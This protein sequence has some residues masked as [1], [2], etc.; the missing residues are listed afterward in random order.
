[1]LTSLEETIR[2]VS[3]SASPSVV[4]V[5]QN[6]RGS[7]FVVAKN[8]VLT[9][10][11]NLRDRS[12]AITFADSRMAQGILHGA[13]IDGD[14][15]VIEVDTADVA[16]LT[17]VVAAESATTTGSAVVAPGHRAICRQPRL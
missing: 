16:P 1:M 5:G 15:V 10:G 3:T 7:G 2:S 8:R 17:I 9:S 11:H 13:D 6:A 12:V 4:S 14:L